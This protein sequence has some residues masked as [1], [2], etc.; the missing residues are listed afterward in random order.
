MKKIIE[1]IP[2]NKILKELNEYTFVRNTN[3]SNH[4]IYIVNHIN[5]P[6]TLLE[7]GRLRELTFRNAGGGTGK[8]VDLDNYDTR[9]DAFYEQLIVWDPDQSKIIGGYRFIKG[10][11][12]G[13]IIKK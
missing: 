2:R 3:Y 4:E 12:A 5:C 9:S 1:P 8:E 6:N 11:K 10:E 13:E 7:I